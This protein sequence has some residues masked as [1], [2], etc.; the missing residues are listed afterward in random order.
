MPLRLWRT[1]ACGE[2]GARPFGGLTVGKHRS[3]PKLGVEELPTGPG[4]L[5]Q[6]HRCAVEIAV[7]R[8]VVVFGTAIRARSCCC[9]SAGAGR[10]RRNRVRFPADRDV[11]GRETAVSSAIQR[12]GVRHDVRAPRR[13]VRARVRA[14]RGRRGRWRSW[15]SRPTAAGGYRSTSSAQPGSPSPPGPPGAASHVSVLRV[16]CISRP[17]LPRR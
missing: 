10:R 14:R 6:T 2:P 15:Q 9:G 8:P 17:R 3:G 4:H 5:L 11:Q 12:S 16:R 7:S 1:A 13:A